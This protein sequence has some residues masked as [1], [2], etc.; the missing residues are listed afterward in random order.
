LE[1]TCTVG[2]F[3]T[4]ARELGQTEVSYN[5][6]SIQLVDGTTFNTDD[7]IRYL[8]ELEIKRDVT[9]AEIP[10]NASRIVAA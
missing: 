7:P 10:L 8:N 4:A 6:G 1:H 2:V 5:R 3:S 9:M